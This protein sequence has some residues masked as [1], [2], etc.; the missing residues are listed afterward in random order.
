MDMLGIEG[1]GDRHDEIREQLAVMEEWVHDLPVINAGE[2]RIAMER[3]VDFLQR[4]VLVDA[5]Q[6]ERDLFPAAGPR[7][8]VLRAEHG[9]IDRW[10][11]EL[12]EIS[13]G[14]NETRDGAR[15]RST[16]LKLFG[17]LEAHMHCEEVVLARV[18]TPSTSASAST[19]A[20]SLDVG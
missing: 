19:T 9:F 16:A 6:E 20:S 11:H 5:R 15:F 2:R 7:A 4:Y 1:M 3:I 18:V 13:R 12:S 17:L 10:V 8:D 14:D